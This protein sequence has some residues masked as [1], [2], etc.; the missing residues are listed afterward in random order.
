MG[1][2]MDNEI[3]RSIELDPSID[4][5][6]NIKITDSGL[7][8]SDLL[9]D[10][11]QTR[12]SLIDNFY[13]T[14]D[15]SSWENTVVSDIRELTTIYLMTAKIIAKSELTAFAHDSALND[16][17]KLI[18]GDSYNTELADLILEK[19][20]REDFNELPNIETVDAE[21][22]AGANGAFADTT[23]SIYL[24]NQFIEA[25]YTNPEVIAEVLLKEVGHYLDSQVNREDAPRDEGEIFSLLVGNKAIEESN[26]QEDRKN[27]IEHSNDL[28]DATF[29]IDP[30]GYLE[31]SKDNFSSD[32]LWQNNIQG[33][34]KVDLYK[35]NR[36]I[37]T[38]LN[39][40]PYRDN[41]IISLKDL[42]PIISELSKDADY[43]LKVSLV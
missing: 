20:G 39:P 5:L 2:A 21:A 26:L 34:F 14:I 40:D 15:F 41:Q 12:H 23:N 43:S 3:N 7:Q 32:S 28:G 31:L 6:G 8:K 24:S 22:I 30:E 17:L 27:T 42:E 9:R 37:T 25:N 1:V 13:D 29:S 11:T 35:D 10:F 4:L 36:F 33:D 38:L 19:F 16:R 18:F